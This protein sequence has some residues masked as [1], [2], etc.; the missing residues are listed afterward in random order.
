MP[1]RIYPRNRFKWECVRK[2]KKVITIRCLFCDKSLS[3]I[4]VCFTFHNKKRLKMHPLNREWNQLN[5][6]KA[7]VSPPWKHHYSRKNH[8]KLPPPPPQVIWTSLQVTFKW[9][10]LLLVARLQSNSRAAVWPFP[11]S[12]WKVTQ[13]FNS[14]LQFHW[15]KYN[16]ENFKKQKAMLLLSQN[17]L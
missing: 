9:N 1:G 16:M 6:Y 5:H 10:V 11:A 7:K 2:S 15:F 3:W 13:S 14:H 4:S 17:Y 8:V 12:L